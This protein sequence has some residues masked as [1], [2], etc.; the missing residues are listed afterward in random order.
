[1]TKFAKSNPELM[2]TAAAAAAGVGSEMLSKRGIRAS[3]DELIRQA[4]ALKQAHAKAGNPEVKRMVEAALVKKLQEISQA[5]SEHLQRGGY[6][7]ALSPQDL[8]QYH[9]AKQA[10]RAYRALL[11]Q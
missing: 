9:E 5:K 8:K 6:L 11:K 7:V 3:P 1:M 10:K 4:Q 2:A